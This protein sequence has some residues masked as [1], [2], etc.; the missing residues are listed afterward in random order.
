MDEQQ[1]ALARL[2]QFQIAWQKMLAIAAAE[3][4]PDRPATVEDRL[5]AEIKNEAIWLQNALHQFRSIP[6]EERI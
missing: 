1:V 2:D 6:A 3:V 4:V 5:R